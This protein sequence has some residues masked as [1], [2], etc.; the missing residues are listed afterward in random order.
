MNAILLGA[1]SLGALVMLFTHG[2]S[3]ISPAQAIADDAEVERLMEAAPDKGSLERKT[4]V[5]PKTGEKTDATVL[6]FKD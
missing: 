4:L 1:A 2:P 3:D 5:D 6:A